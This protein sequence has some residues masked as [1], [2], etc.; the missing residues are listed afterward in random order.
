M[1]AAKSANMEKYSSQNSPGTRDLFLA[2]DGMLRCRPK[3]GRKPV[4]RNR[5]PHI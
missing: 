5:E 1:L 2:C 3:P 4:D